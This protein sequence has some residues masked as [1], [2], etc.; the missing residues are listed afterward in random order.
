MSNVGRIAGLLGDPVSKGVA[1]TSGWQ[2]RRFYP[3]TGVTFPCREGT[4]LSRIVAR[5]TQHH[6][7]RTA[8]GE[9]CLELDLY[10]RGT[11]AGVGCGRPQRV[12]I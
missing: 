5:R 4:Q 12:I 8:A 2:V 6:P 1:G 11:T 10:Q 7:W 9:R 3:E